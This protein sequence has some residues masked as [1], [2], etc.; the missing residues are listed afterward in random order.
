MNRE[1]ILLTV[2]LYASL[3]AAGLCAALRASFT[4]LATGCDSLHTYFVAKSA[5]CRR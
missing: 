2:K 5:H 1:Q 3:A 4:W